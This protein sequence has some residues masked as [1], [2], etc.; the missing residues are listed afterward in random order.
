MSV[1]IQLSITKLTKKSVVNQFPD[2]VKQIDYHAVAKS[3]EHP[4]IIETCA[5]TIQLNTDGLSE[6][7]FINF[8]DLDEDLVISWILNDQNVNEIEELSFIKFILFQIKTKTLQ[9]QEEAQVSK[10]WK[11]DKVLGI[12]IDDIEDPTASVDHVLPKANSFSSTINSVVPTINS[13]V[14]TADPIVDPIVLPVQETAPVGIASTETLVTEA[15]ADLGS[16]VI[17]EPTEE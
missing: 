15:I 5:G 9:L 14:P 7:D 17:S 10:S 2:V 6:E 12:S 1:E 3:I 16:V 8:E 11:V 4:T 13:V